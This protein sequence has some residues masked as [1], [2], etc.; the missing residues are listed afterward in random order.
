MKKTK[1]FQILSLSNFL[2]I[3]SYF[4]FISQCEIIKTGPIRKYLEL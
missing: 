4:M 3:F 1:D 2:F